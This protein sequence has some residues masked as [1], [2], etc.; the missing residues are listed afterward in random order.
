M[1]NIRRYAK[2]GQGLQNLKKFCADISHD[3][4][5]YFGCIFNYKNFII[6]TK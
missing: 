6:E 4:G 3:E 2:Y 1:K 5:L